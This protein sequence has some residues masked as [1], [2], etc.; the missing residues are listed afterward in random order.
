[1]VGLREKNKERNRRQIIAAAK[2]LIKENNS[3]DFTMVQLAE[4][5]GVSTYTTYN[6]IGSKATVLYILLNNL[7]DEISIPPVVHSRDQAEHIKR[8]VK[9]G[10]APVDLY[11]NDEGLYRPLTRYLL[12]SVHTEERAKYQ[13]KAWNY[14]MLAVSGVESAGILRDDLSSVD[15]VRSVNIGFTG[16]MEFWVHSELSAAGLRAEARTMLALNLISFC[17]ERL[18]PV[19]IDIVKSC[20]HLIEIPPKARAGKA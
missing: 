13:K 2:Q 19:A 18:R 7:V 17:H 12:G 6:L 15:L 1:M 20:R 4:E 14:W 8:F 16:I 11:V 3:T 9:F 10:D 5:A